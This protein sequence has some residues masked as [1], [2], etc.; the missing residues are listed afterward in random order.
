MK[1]TPSAHRPTCI[2]NGLCAARSAATNAT[3]PNTSHMTFSMTG[4]PLL[5]AYVNRATEPAALG[6]HDWAEPLRAGFLAEAV[7]GRGDGPYG[8]ACALGHSRPRIGTI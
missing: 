5:S 4:T 1:R 6:Q 8:R 3:P 2:A 7:A